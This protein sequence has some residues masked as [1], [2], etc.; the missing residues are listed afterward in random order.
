MNMKR[1]A[2]FI[3][4]S[5]GSIVSDLIKKETDSQ[6]THTGVIIDSSYFTY[7]LS[8]RFESGKVDIVTLDYYQNLPNYIYQI[9]NIHIPQ[10]KIDAILKDFL[11]KYWN[12]KYGYMQLIGYYIQKL[13][14]LKKNPFKK[15][16][17]CT[18]L[19]SIYLKNLMIDFTLEVNNW[20]INSVSVGQIQQYLIRNSNY[21]TL[22]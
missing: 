5:T 1:G 3:G 6:W 13:L 18:E 14:K 8:A 12:Q 9:F 4:S 20:D 10:E 16:I 7:I 19:M 11:I 22:L 15:N 2:I 21:F 17:D